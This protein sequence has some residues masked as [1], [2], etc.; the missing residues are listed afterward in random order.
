MLLWKP[1]TRLTGPVSETYYTERSTMKI[2]N[3]DHVQEILKLTDSKR[4][5]CTM[6][7]CHKLS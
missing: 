1:D 5:P 2:N 6:F 4:N 3:A 7:L